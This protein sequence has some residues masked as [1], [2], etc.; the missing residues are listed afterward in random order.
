MKRIRLPLYLKILVWFFLNLVLL[1]GVFALLFQIQFRLN[2]N[3]LITTGARERIEAARDLVVGELNTT[4]PDEWA[5]V[6]D[7]FSAAYHVRFALFDDEGFPLVG[8]FH[9][10]PR[11]VRERIVAGPPNSARRWRGAQSEATRP[12]SSPSSS[13]GVS[14]PAER[15]WHLPV[16]ALMRTTHPTQYWLLTSARVDNPQVGDPM[17]VILVA[18]SASLSAGRLIFNPTPWLW[19]G[20]GVVVFSLLFWLPL[21]RSITRSIGRMT[22]ATRQIAEGRF[23][24]RVQMPRR[25]ELG[26]LAESIDQ[27]ATRLDG[28]VTG[29]KRF[30]GD[31]AHEL[32]SPLARL[33][34]ALGVLDQRATGEQVKFVHS[35]I[36]KAEQISSLVGELL[37]FSK[38]SF[39]AS[40]L[41]LRPV[42]VRAAAEEAI[43]RENGENTALVTLEASPDLFVAS[44]PDL[45]V[46]VLA[47]LLRNAL[48]HAAPISPGGPI[49][50]Q[51]RT[52]STGTVALIVSDCGKGVPEEELPRIFEPFYRL[53]ASR[54]R[55][56]GGV[57]LGLAIVK[58]GVQSCCGTVTARNRQPHGLEVRIELPA[59][60]PPTQAQAT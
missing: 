37:S 16:R 17:R 14:P 47:N 27:M 11:E 25:D 52:T 50:L 1:A 54:T 53:D 51:A 32:C 13:P 42:N 4:Q 22:H 30:L 5:H 9:E 34:L 15:R 19:L 23:D 39:G 43:R 10:L 20:L 60:E 45:L 33:Q 31:I 57:G 29:Q 49:T 28:F 44:D 18:N 26:S 36:E 3:W 38:A 35:A 24:V 2:L 12:S 6:L 58:A 21:V 55:E 8:Q 7:R 48:R 59:T 41:R 56:T 40:A 46:R